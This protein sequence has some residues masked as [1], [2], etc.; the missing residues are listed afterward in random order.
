MHA[1]C[2]KFIDCKLI[3]VKLDISYVFGY[4]L[5]N[6]SIKDF[7][8]LYRGKEVNLD[9][10]EQAMKFLENSRTYELINVFFYLSRI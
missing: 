10:K 1:E 3:N 6:T 7:K 5:C 2:H 9:C 4:L 8:I